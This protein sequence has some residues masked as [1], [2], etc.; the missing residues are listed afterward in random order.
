MIHYGTHL[1]G[2]VKEPKQI[3]RL[4]QLEKQAEVDL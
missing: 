3:P 2:F 4:T 1:A